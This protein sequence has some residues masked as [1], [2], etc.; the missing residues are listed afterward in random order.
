MVNNTVEN[1]KGVTQ[2]VQWEL[3]RMTEIGAQYRYSTYECVNARR[4][5]D[6]KD[7]YIY[8]KFQNSH[9]FVVD[10]GRP[11]EITAADLKLGYTSWEKSE[12]SKA[13]YGD[14]DLDTTNHVL[15]YTPNKVMLRC[16]KSNTEFNRYR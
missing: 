5:D 12:V 9:S 6:G 1:I 2:T 14:V 11:L 15:V 8:Y 7:V 4:S 3:A 16:R 13:A 10:Y